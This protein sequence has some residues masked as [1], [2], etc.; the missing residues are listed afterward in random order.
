MFY[1]ILTIVILVVFGTIFA[2]PKQPKE[3]TGGNQVETIQSSIEALND[4]RSKIEQL[5]E[6]I[7]TIAPKLPA[8]T[9]VIDEIQTTLASFQ[10]DF[11]NTLDN[12][13]SN[14]ETQLS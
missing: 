14:V 3:Q 2:A 5:K 11:F 9:S 8:Q 13:S 4:L 12:I 7:T 6:T 10:T 1:V